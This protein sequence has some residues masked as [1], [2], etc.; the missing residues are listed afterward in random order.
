[1]ERQISQDSTVDFN[2]RGE[3]TYTLNIAD[4]QMNSEELPQLPSHVDL[5]KKKRDQGCCS[6][7]FSRFSAFVWRNEAELLKSDHLQAAPC[8][9]TMCLAILRLI[10]SLALVTQTI[11]CLVQTSK[12]DSTSFFF[13]SQWNL[14]LITTLFTTMATIQIKHERRLKTF[15]VDVNPIMRL[16]SG[17]DDGQPDIIEEVSETDETTSDEGA[18]P[19]D[20]F[21]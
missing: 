1:M 7:C 16:D 2:P 18:D 8:V 5:M 6:S 17:M 21:D 20:K 19:D 10:I 12:T 11:A 15:T 13:I 3:R 9:S 4:A 14:L